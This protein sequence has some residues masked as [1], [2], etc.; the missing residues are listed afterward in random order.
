M[1]AKE[2]VGNKKKLTWWQDEFWKHMVKKYPELERGESASETG[3]AHIP[4]RLFKEAMYLTRMKDQILQILAE[5]NPLNKRSKA[6][7]LENL[8]GKYIPAAEAM[9]TKLKNT[10]GFIAS[11]PRRRPRWRRN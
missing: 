8:L 6:E 3:R 10:M 9:R 2:I 4:P 11:L 1:S 5:T 7:E